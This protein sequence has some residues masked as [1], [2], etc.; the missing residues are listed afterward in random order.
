MTGGDATGRFQGSQPAPLVLQTQGPLTA[1]FG[2]KLPPTHPHMGLPPGPAP[3]LCCSAPDPR[4]LTLG[5]CV[6]QDTSPPLSLLE[7]VS[8]A[9]LL[10]RQLLADS[11]TTV[12]HQMTLV[13]P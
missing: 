1:S 11:P 8:P 13:P 5:H 9:S 2:A 6:P 4:T 7:A 12:F 10:S 3:R